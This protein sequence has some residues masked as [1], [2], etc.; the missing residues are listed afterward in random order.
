MEK[1]LQ[2]TIRWC[3]GH[4][5]DSFATKLHFELVAWIQRRAI[6][7]LAETAKFRKG[8]H[9]PSV[10]EVKLPQMTRVAAA[11]ASQHSFVKLG[12]T[13]NVPKITM[14]AFG[15]DIASNRLAA[16]IYD[17]LGRADYEEAFHRVNR[18]GIKLG[19]GLSDSPAPVGLYKALC[20]AGR[21]SELPPKQ[22]AVFEAYLTR[23]LS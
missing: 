15:V 2:V 13:I 1:S 17:E 8:L 11:V 21:L 23:K 6:V 18:M 3:K 16:C 5:K 22:Q 4:A 9:E 14:K 19:F 7:I 10:Q 12:K 20:D